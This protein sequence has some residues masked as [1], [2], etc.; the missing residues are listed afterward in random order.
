MGQNKGILRMARAGTDRRRRDP[1]VNKRADATKT[2]LM[3]PESAK[4]LKTMT[5]HTSKA[6]HPLIPLLPLHSCAL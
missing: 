1:L 5:N 4:E 3:G 6:S 2:G